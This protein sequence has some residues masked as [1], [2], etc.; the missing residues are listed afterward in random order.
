MSGRAAGTVKGSARAEGGAVAATDPARIRNVALVGPSGSGKTSLVEALLAHTGTIPRAGTVTDG[1]SPEELEAE[2]AR[3]AEVRKKQTEAQKAGKKLEPE[4]LTDKPWR[5]GVGARNTLE[6]FSYNLKFRVQAG[7][8]KGQIDPK[9][10]AQHVA[11]AFLGVR[12]EC[13]ECHKHPHDQWS[14]QDFFSFTR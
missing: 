13:A 7:P 8:R 5:V 1:M 4:P 14:Q 6:E 9:P 11:T 3:R 10:M 12:L 2:N